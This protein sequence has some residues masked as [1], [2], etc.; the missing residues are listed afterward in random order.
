MC[1][2]KPFVY[3]Q[4]DCPA[5]SANTRVSESIGFGDSS[6]PIAL[7]WTT[8]SRRTSAGGLRACPGTLKLGDGDIVLSGSSPTHSRRQTRTQ[9]PAR[10][11]LLLSETTAGGAG[12]FGQNLLVQKLVEMSAVGGGARQVRTAV[13]GKSAAVHVSTTID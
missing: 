11:W 7:F 5:G 1:Y 3:I 4:L 13:H 12:L 10:D 2:A 9:T 6:Y 8:F